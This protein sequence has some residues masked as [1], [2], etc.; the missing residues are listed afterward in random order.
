MERDLIKRSTIALP[1]QLKPSN[2]HLDILM[3][4]DELI[5]E[6]DAF[7]PS[8]AL[9]AEGS[10]HSKSDFHSQMERKYKI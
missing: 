9:G 5:D 1:G 6:S 8:I 7:L 10:S 4:R 3:G 2:L